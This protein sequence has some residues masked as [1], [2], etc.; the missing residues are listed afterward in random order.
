MT[1]LKSEFMTFHDRIALNSGKKEALRKARNAIRDRI[2]KYFRENLKVRLPGFLGQGSYAMGTTVNPLSGEFDID[3]G[4]YLQHLDGS[5]DS[6]WPTPETVHRWLVNAT[7]GHTKEKPIDKRTCIRVRYAG[8]YHVDLPPYANLND[9]YMLAERGKKGWHRSDPLALTVWFKQKVQVNGEQLRRLVRYLKAWADFQSGRRGKMPSGLILTVLAAQHFCGDERDDVS[10]ANTSQA[11]YNAVYPIFC[12][13]NPVDN[14][15]E[16]T[17]RLTDEQKQRF[18][19]AISDLSSDAANAIANGDR[20]EASNL[21]RR[22]VGD[23]FPL[24]ETSIEAGQKQKDVAKLASVYAAKNPA[25][26]W[27]HL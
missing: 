7:D 8:Q 27:A 10:L 24:I 18:Q 19:D 2:R 1:D 25:K 16:L 13:Y 11:I 26:P 20:E 17:A 5:N 6:N 14:Q 3:D 9:E 15:E 21:W 22:Q 23:R 12:V 4:V